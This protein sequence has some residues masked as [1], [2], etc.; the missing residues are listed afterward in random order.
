MELLRK[1]VFLDRDGTINRDSA[2]YIKSRSEF[3][4]IP[5]SIDAIKN[6]TAHGFTSIVITNQS[7]LARKYVSPEEL[8]AMHDLMINTVASYGG[9]ITD[10]LYCPHMPDDGCDCRKPAPGL[11]F[12]A[13]QKYNID[14]A[15]AIVVGDSLKDIECGRNA[16]CGTTVLV[17]SGI[18]SDVED[19]LKNMSISADSVAMN[20][21]EAAEWIIKRHSRD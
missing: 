2:E 18:H 14:L 16:G 1:V 5:G 17:K 7:A 9:K 11:I 12:Q 6:L 4:F 13:R 8:D 15:D 21:L 10:V 20:L 19:P 3:D